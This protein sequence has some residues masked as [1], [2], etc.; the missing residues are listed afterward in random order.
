MVK[1][2]TRRLPL[3]NT[4]TTRR[5][6]TAV[7]KHRILVQR[8]MSKFTNFLHLVAWKSIQETSQLSNIW[9]D[10]PSWAVKM[11]QPKA[12]L[13][14]RWCHHIQHR[15]ILKS[16]VH[17]SLLYRQ[18]DKIIPV[19]PSGRRSQRTRW[20]SVP[21]VTSLYPF[22]IR[23]SPIATAFAFTCLA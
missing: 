3:T 16:G 12:S 7:S 10:L 4:H 5:K 22:F 21:S 18:R 13:V 8:N 19:R 15:Y 20:F 14:T 11:T 1:T 23:P 9:A 2:W 17:T 6:G